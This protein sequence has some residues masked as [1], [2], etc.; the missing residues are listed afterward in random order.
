MT[1]RIVMLQDGRIVRDIAPGCDLPP[2]GAVAG[3][4]FILRFEML[5]SPILANSS[6]L[7]I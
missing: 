2:S 7:K 3:R 5:Y 6:H 4:A 1:D